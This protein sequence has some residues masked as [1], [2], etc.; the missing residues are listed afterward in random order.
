[1]NRCNIFK[2][3]LLAIFYGHLIL[4]I[5]DIFNLYKYGNELFS[6]IAFTCGYIAYYKLK[7]NSDSIIKN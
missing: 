2:Y 5:L 7:C 4:L 1:M 3:I 6:L